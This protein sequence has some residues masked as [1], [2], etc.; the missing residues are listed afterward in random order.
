[1]SAQGD[2]PVVVLVLEHAPHER[3]AVRVDAGRGEAEHDVA[4]FDAEPSSGSSVDDPDARRGEIELALAVDAG[5]LG[6]LA[7]DERDAGLAANLRGALDQLR[8][9]LQVDMPGGDIVEEDQR[10]GAARDHVVDAVRRHVGAAVAEC[11]ARA[12]DDRLRPDRVGRGGEEAAVAERMERRE[13]RRSPCAPVDS[14]AA[15]RRSTTA[16]AVASETPAVSY[17]RAFSPIRRV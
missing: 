3:E 16:V 5:H 2:R 1:M 14:T 13:M 6:G 12:G 8:D 15:R 11:A 7:A 4:R 10:L 9:L 17:V